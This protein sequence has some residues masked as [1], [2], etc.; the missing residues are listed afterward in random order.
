VIARWKQ[1]FPHL[2]RLNELRLALRKAA[3]GF[4]PLDPRVELLPALSCVKRVVEFVHVLCCFNC[5]IHHAALRLALNPLPTR[6]ARRI[7]S[8]L[9]AA[10][11]RA[12]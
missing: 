7:I 10:R 11:S 2:K 12:R 4:Y 1:P 5:A 8:A 6:S 3:R 9:Q